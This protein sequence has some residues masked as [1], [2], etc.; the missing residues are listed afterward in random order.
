MLILTHPPGRQQGIALIESLVALLLVAVGV[1]ALMNLQSL[2]VRNTS[3]AKY[4]SEAAL[5][6]QKR[7][8]DMFVNQENLNSF[9]ETSTDI[10]LETSLPA[11]KRSTQRAVTSCDTSTGNVKNSDC[12]VVEIQWKIPGSQ[13]TR[14]LT[15]TAYITGG[16]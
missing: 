12:F 15:R 10:S 1:I 9:I 14:S 4:R 5:L 8:A 6:A 3:D 16:I 11:A 2:N 13:E 7:I